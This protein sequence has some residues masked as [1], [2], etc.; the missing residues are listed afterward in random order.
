MSNDLDERDAHGDLTDW[1]L[2]CQAMV[3]AGCDCGTDEPGTCF[4]CLCER[5]MKAERAKVVA[6]TTKLVDAGALHLADEQSVRNA[7]RVIEGSST[8]IR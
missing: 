6:L 2:A 8:F 7:E 3:D 5:A 1:A 4:G